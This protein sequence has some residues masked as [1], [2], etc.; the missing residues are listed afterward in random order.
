MEPKPLDAEKGNYTINT[1]G[2]IPR[3]DHKIHKWEIRALDAEK[4]NVQVQRD[5]KNTSNR[6]TNKKQ[7]GSILKSN[8]TDLNL[9]WD[10]AQN[11]MPTPCSSY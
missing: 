4:V 1:K 2:T 10:S 6:N 5:V 11:K 7:N 3:Q 9:H 8:P